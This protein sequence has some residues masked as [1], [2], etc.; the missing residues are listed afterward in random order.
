MAISIFSHMVS[1]RFFVRGREDGYDINDV[2]SNIYDWEYDSIE[3]EAYQDGWVDG[4]IAY[5]KEQGMSASDAAD[6]C[7]RDM[8]DVE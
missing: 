4:R 7:H 5:Y 1:N 6:A 3:A 8:Y 2:Y